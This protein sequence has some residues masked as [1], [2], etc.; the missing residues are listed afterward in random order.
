MKKTLLFMFAF[1]A[2]VT[3]ALAEDTTVQ[4]TA[5]TD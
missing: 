4:W 5:N 2:F 3:S 1:M